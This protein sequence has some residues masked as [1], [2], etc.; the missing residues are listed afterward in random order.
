[1]LWFYHSI[2]F[3]SACS[4]PLHQEIGAVK[5]DI[6]R[7][8]SYLREHLNSPRGELE[9]DRPVPYAGEVPASSLLLFY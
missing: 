7:A 2:S 8:A 3:V 9:I 6:K 1:M 5:T 4:S